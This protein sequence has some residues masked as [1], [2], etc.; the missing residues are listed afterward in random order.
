MISLINSVPCS[1]KSS[2]PAP[3][4]QELGE[5]REEEL[6][7]RRQR[8]ALALRVEHQQLVQ[9]EADATQAAMRTAR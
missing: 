5:T 1:A 7:V 8:R 2:A 6:L 9:A 3:I 4:R